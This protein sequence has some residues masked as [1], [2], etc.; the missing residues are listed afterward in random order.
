VLT[1]L[2]GQYFGVQ[3]ASGF[4]H[5][6]AGWAIYLFAFVSLLATY[7]LLRTL[8]SRRWRRSA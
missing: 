7:S 1:G 5:E 3:Y 4:F 8:S 2:I 6:F